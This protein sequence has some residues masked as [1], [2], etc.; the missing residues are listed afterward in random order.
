MNIKD[1]RTVNAVYHLLTGKQSIQ[2]IQDAH[3]F[4]LERYYSLYKH[5]QIEQFNSALLSLQQA[6][7]IEMYHDNKSRVT[8]LGRQSL[9]VNELAQYDW[10]GKAYGQ[11]DELFMQRLFLLIQVWTNRSA[12]IK[13]Y[14]P[15][16]DEAKVIHWVKHFYY[17]EGSNVEKNL[18]QLYEELLYVFS[19][20][21]NLYPKIFIKQMTTSKSI[22]LTNEQLARKYH[23][24]IPHIYLLQKSYIHFML[25]QIQADRQ[26]FELLYKVSS[27]LLSDNG[28]KNM[29]NS[30]QSTAYLVKQ[31]LTP[32]EIASK[33][34]LRITTIYDHIVELA[35]H[36]R[37]FPMERFVSIE[38]Q[39]EI[40]EAVKRLNSFKLKD[41]KQSVTDHISYFQIRLAL[42]KFNS[43]IVK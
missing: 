20:I 42:T 6:S 1:E 31:G 43:D 13:R 12:H 22:G 10:D 23:K 2:T 26:A 11:L 35:L 38:T 21:D 37:Q 4:Q 28:V 24:S 18:H 5:L 3:L 15:I 33:R 39:R 16:V 40:Y 27:D 29:T 17:R 9:Q 19:S 8:S 30:A 7:Y 14:I 32:Q 25:S 34:Y 41:I 36:D